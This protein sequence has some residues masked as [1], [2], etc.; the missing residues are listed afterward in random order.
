MTKPD[1]KRAGRV[2]ST[3]KFC[4]SEL[5]FFLTAW[6]INA[7][8]ANKGCLERESGSSKVLIDIRPEYFSE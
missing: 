6:L 2:L 1:K 3:R 5:F 4:F 8:E 7:I